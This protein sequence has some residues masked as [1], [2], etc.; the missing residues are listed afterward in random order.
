MKKEYFEPRPEIAGKRLIIPTH[1]DGVY[2]LLWVGSSMNESLWSEKIGPQLEKLYDVANT[3]DLKSVSAENFK[4][5]IPALRDALASDGWIPLKGY[6]QFLTSFA[7]DY[8]ES[9]R[10]KS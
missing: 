6:H 5:S 4:F 10:S 8:E 1:M 7:F 9:Q 2:L 3:F